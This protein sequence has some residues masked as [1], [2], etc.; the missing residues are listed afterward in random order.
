MKIEMLF[1][2]VHQLPNVPEVV[3]TLICQLSDP[4]ID[5]SQVSSQVV[6]DQVI[7]LKVLRLVNSAHFGL[8]RKVASIDEAVVMLGMAKLK[9]I[10]IA[11]GLTSSITRVEG[12]D[13][14]Q[15]WRESL[16]VAG[17]AKSLASLND[18]VDPDT[19]FTAGLLADLG[20][21]LIH[22][23]VPDLAA[24]IATDVEQGAGQTYSELKYLGF[25]SNEVG[26]ELM[27]RWHFPQVLADG[28]RVC[29]QPGRTTPLNPLG[30]IIYVASYLTRCRLREQDFD[31][32]MTYFPYKIAAAIGLDHHEM[33][34]SLDAIFDEAASLEAVL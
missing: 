11:S 30:V 23:G 20:R 19:A 5:L 14:R 17:V 10:V 2:Q 9:T 12:L 28:I 27:Q 15:F 33:E 4:D 24:Q 6:K 13:M 29:R 18:W 7:S 8:T 31:T 1:D 16:H 26:A 25:A 3:Q 32:I 21:V 22:L 34:V